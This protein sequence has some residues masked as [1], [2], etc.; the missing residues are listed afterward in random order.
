MIM[1]HNLWQE[2]LSG[3]FA[4]ASS[5]VWKGRYQSLLQEAEG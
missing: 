4:L 1:T 3:A 2:Q 5:C